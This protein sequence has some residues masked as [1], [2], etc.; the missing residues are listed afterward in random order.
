VNKPSKEPLTE[1]ELEFLRLLPVDSLAQGMNGAEFGLLAKDL[2][3]DD[4]EGEGPLR[5]CM[6][7]IRELGRKG[8][9]VIYYE[10]NWCF[11]S[12]A[13]SERL[14][15]LIDPMAVYRRRFVSKPDK[16][17]WLPRIMMMPGRNF[18]GRDE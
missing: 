7:I 6:D 9:E 16:E 10:S 5:F 4:L 14:A 3:H 18:I 15:P 17:G 11:M 8:I 1:L 2:K 13:E 12:R